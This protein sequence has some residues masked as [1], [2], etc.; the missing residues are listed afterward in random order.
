[1]QYV[2][3]FEYKGILIFAWILWKNRVINLKQ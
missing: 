2:N 3:V 1:M